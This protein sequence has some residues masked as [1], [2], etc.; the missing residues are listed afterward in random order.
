MDGWMD[1]GRKERRKNEMD[2]W[3][4]GGRNKLI[5]PGN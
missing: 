2:R 4:E 3:R 1:T 5:T